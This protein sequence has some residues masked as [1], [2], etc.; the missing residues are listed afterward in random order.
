MTVLISHVHGYCDVMASHLHSQSLLAKFVGFEW[1][2]EVDPQ[3]LG[4]LQQLSVVVVERSI[5]VRVRL[6]KFLH[7]FA[8]HIFIPKGTVH[9]GKYVRE[10]AKKLVNIY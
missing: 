4:G 10:S 7:L 1:R 8:A 5:V 3:V 2:Q 9:L 6:A